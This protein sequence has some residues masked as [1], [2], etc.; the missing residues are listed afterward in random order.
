MRGLDHNVMVERELAQLLYNVPPLYHLS[1]KS[2]LA[3]LPVIQKQDKFFRPLH[4]ALAEKTMDGFAWLSDDRLVQSTSFSDGS[5]LI[6]NFDKMS[7]QA[8]GLTLGPYSI[9]AILAGQTPEAYSAA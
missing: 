5:R 1:E 4:E 7:R 3:R 2:L 9:T 8:D 6:A